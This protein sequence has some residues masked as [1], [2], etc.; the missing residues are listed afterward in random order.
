MILSTW[1]HREDCINPT[2]D[3]EL[4]WRSVKSYDTN[5]KDALERWQNKLYEVE[6]MR[7]D[8]I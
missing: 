3:E 7:C 6:T 5:S 1:M 2:E 4:S 8:H